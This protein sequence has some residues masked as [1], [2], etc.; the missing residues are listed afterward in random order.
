[1]QQSAADAKNISSSCLNFARD[2]RN[3]AAPL[4]SSVH[5]DSRIWFIA[6]GTKRGLVFCTVKDQVVITRPCNENSPTRASTACPTTSYSPRCRICRWAKAQT[7]L[8]RSCSLQLPQRSCTASAAP[9]RT[10]WDTFEVANAHIKFVNSL[11]V[12]RCNIV[13][14]ASPIFLKNKALP[15]AALAKE[16]ARSDKYLG[17]KSCKQGAATA[18]TA[19]YMAHTSAFTARGI[20]PSR[21]D[22]HQ[23]TSA[24][25]HA[26][27][28]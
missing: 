15:C 22:K 18:E 2:H 6:A 10:R 4:Q 25:W 14:L 13:A 17:S 27:C 21:R 24:T 1:M 3:N 7:A 23:T 20:D 8:E 9:I 11:G 26:V 12:M 16:C 5:C 28:L 19:A